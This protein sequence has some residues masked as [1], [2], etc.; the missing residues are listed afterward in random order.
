MPPLIDLNRQLRDRTI[1][2]I[3][4]LVSD[5]DPDPVLDPIVYE[6]T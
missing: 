6:Y 4:H 3:F 2:S 1:R 5:L